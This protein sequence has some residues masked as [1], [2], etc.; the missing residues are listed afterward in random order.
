MS[1]LMSLLISG[2]LALAMA[3]P[4][5]AEAKKN[6]GK[7]KGA[8]A[9]RA[10]GKDNDK[11]L[12]N[13]VLKGVITAAELNTIHDFI[14]RNGVQAF[15]ASQGLPPGIAKNLSR[16]KPLPPGI[17]K[18]FMPQGLLGRLPPRP[19]YEWEVVDG[20]ILL[21]ETATRVIVDVLKDIL[22]N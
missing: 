15:G 9:E 14:R 17:A 6:K 5:F 12:G 16:G 13:I 20:D 7:H 19:G 10:A 2:L 1:R 3:Q 22:K 8:E 4:A 21:V 18:R 11:D